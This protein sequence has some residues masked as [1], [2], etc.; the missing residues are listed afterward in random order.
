M[1]SLPIETQKS[2]ISEIT[3][4]VPDLDRPVVI[5]RKVSR[6]KLMKNIYNIKTTKGTF[7][8]ET[9]SNRFQEFFQDHLEDL[10]GMEVQWTDK[11][12]VNFGFVN[13]QFEATRKQFDYDKYTVLFGLSGFDKDLGILTISKRGHIS[14][15]GI[16][17][18]A[19][20]KVTKGRHIL[21]K[22]QTGD[23]IL[24]VGLEEVKS[25]FYDYSV[26]TSDDT[27]NDGDNIITKAV[28]ELYEDCPFATEHFLFLIRNG[29]MRID[30]RNNSYCRNDEMKGISLPRE[31]SNLR[32][33]GS[34]S[35]R[36]T[37]KG[38]GSVFIYLID[39]IED[40]SHSVVGR[41]INGLELPMNISP[42]QCFSIS[43][44]TKRLNTLGISQKE[45]EE[46][47]KSM[48]IE[49][50]RTGDTN[51]DAIVVIQNPE[52]SIEAQKAG[53]ISTEG[54]DPKFVFKIRLYEDKAPVSVKYF[55][56]ISGMA[57]RQLGRLDVLI[58]HK[59]L[60]MILF[61]GDPKMAG[62]L[63]PENPPIEGTKKGRIGITN[64]ASRQ[65]G[66]IGVRFSDSEEYGPTGEDFYHTNC[67]GEFLN[68][69]KLRDI[70]EGSTIYLLLE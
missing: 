33:K 16:E 61:K 48:G 42:G 60:D 47:A 57:T 23:K 27:V 3:G 44:K 55:K 38:K 62:E 66:T 12:T 25:E 35:V 64:M 22:I 14:R 49:H 9:F 46:I 37:G 7:T 69:D 10:M 31:K 36:N 18:S 54:V 29:L 5:E 56:T 65:M 6:S 4:I 13:T 52:I 20:G 11:N 59:D 50:E 30:E 40:E 8:I 34:I 26:I 58:A 1:D 53:K 68:H 24:E 17:K 39:A 28:V 21:E 32:D 63:P 45:A 67:V 43:S 2:L 51:D 70:E 19:F 41:I 15:N